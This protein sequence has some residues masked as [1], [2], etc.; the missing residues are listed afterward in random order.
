M[1]EHLSL[2]MMENWPATGWVPAGGANVAGTVC[3]AVAQIP[4]GT[5]SGECG[6][7]RTVEVKFMATT[8]AIC[9]L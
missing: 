4:I 2:R 9:F 8:E 1:Q 5:D 7:L 3:W 6:F